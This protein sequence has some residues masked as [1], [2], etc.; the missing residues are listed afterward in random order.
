NRGRD[1]NV[2]PCKEKKL[3]NMR[4]AAKDDNVIFAPIKAM[5]LE[6]AIRCIREDE[7]MEV[8]PQSIRMRKAVLSA[9]KR[10]T[11]RGASQKKKNGG[12]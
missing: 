6:Q 3:S 5:T 4:A 12:M 7:L 11:L 10:R 8:T 9:Q 2:N 1:I